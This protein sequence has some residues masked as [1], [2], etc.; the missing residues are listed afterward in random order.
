MSTQGFLL[1]LPGDTAAQKISRDLGGW[2]LVKPQPFTAKL[3]RRA[4]RQRSQ[5]FVKRLRHAAISIVS[6]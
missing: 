4:C 1:H 6:V 3:R 5:L 2:Y